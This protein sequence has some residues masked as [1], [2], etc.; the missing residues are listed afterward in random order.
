[1]SD[2]DDIEEIANAADEAGE[3]I[4]EYLVRGGLM[5]ARMETDRAFEAETLGVED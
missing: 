4:G 2:T 3:S 5:R 1:M